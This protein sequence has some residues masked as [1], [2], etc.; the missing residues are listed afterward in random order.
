M[1]F[2]AVT[3]R[4]SASEISRPVSSRTSRTAQASGVSP[5]SRCPPGS[6]IAPAEGR[7]VSFGR[8]CFECKKRGLACAVAALPNAGDETA[9]FVHEKDA[10]ADPDLRNFS[11]S[12]PKHLC[13]GPEGPSVRSG[14]ALEDAQISEGEETVSPET[15]LEVTSS[16][17]STLGFFRLK[18]SRTAS[19][20][21]SLARLCRRSSAPFSQRRPRL[22]SPPRRGCRSSRW[23]RP[24][25]PDRMQDPSKQL[26]GKRYVPRPAK[27]RQ[28]SLRV[29]AD[30]AA[31]RSTSHCAAHHRTP[32][33]PPRD[34]ERLG[35]TP[36]PCPDARRRRRVRRVSLYRPCRQRKVP[37][38]R[39]FPGISPLTWIE[40]RS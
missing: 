19:T 33:N 8:I 36:A 39:A 1:S 9:V 22:V 3:K 32:A 14:C 35:R 15:R 10:D 40:P 4:T 16:F 21:C 38:P 18:R 31:R 5:N 17:S 23:P 25:P 26:S 13:T 30:P 12:M 28:L 2:V 7:R 27:G 11:Q 20:G 37:R 24:P 6:W 29:P 34:L